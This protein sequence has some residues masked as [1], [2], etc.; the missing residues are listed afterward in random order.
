MYCKKNYLRATRVVQTI[1]NWGGGIAP[2]PGKI[3]ET[4]AT[5]VDRNEIH[6]AGS[7]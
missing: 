5:V 1:L 6:A 4:R 3:Y 2:R 7:G